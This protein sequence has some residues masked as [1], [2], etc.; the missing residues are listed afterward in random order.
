VCAKS[1][2]LLCEQKKFVVRVR[3]EEEMCVR[4]WGPRTPETE[5]CESESPL[6][7][8]IDLQRTS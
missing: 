1:A 8:P 3:E 5:E 4:V 2:A 7:S 6:F